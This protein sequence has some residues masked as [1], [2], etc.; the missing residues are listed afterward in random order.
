[1]RL[2]LK[3]FQKGKILN[4]K[5]IT[6]KSIVTTTKLYSLFSLHKREEYHF[7]VIDRDEL[8]FAKFKIHECKNYLIRNNIIPLKED[9]TSEYNINLDKFLKQYDLYTCYG[10]TG[11]LFS[12]RAVELLQEELKDEVEFIPC[13]IK[14]EKV[15]IYAALFLKSAPIIQ[16]FKGMGY[17]FYP[18]QTID[19]EYAIM[20]QEMGIKFV[21]QKF[22]DLVQKH[23]L[24]MEFELKN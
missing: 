11:D 12:E 7:L 21:T 16:D 8:I 1:M 14:G 4:L 20:D 3:S 5:C 2:S 6:K 17:D 23:Q 24:K 13:A 15:K 9:F 19:A 10:A 22:V 18:F